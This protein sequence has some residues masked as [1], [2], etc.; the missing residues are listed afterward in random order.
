MDERAD[1]EVLASMVG[2]SLAGTLGRRGVAYVRWIA[3]CGYP[4]RDEVNDCLFQ[5][6]TPADT[7]DIFNCFLLAD[8]QRCAPL[9]ER[10]V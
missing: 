9:R 4:D 7:V 6:P 8:G 10:N 5:L 3:P 2:V 1:D